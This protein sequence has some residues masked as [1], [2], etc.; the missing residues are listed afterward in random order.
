MQGALPVS[1]IISAVIPGSRTNFSFS[2]E[3]DKTT[4]LWHVA[5]ETV[6]PSVSENVKEEVQLQLLESTDTGD[7]FHRLIR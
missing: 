6:Q 4:K 3:E 7:S 5:E 1:Y 2:C